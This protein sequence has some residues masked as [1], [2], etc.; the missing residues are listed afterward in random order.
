[1]FCDFVVTLCQF[2][3]SLCEL[4]I[5]PCGFFHLYVLWLSYYVS[6]LHHNVM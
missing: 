6:S 3:F 5:I 2:V 1:M 4:V